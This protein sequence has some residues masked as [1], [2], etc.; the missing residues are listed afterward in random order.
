[1]PS[2]YRIKHDAYVSE[3]VNGTSDKAPSQN[4]GSTTQQFEHH[5]QKFEGG[6][7]RYCDYDVKRTGKRVYSQ[8][9]LICP[10][11][12]AVRLHIHA[13]ENGVLT[14]SVWKRFAQKIL[15]QLGLSIYYAR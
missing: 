14:P 5:L 4:D 15:E 10:E 3:D 1:M 2:K 7:L 11:Q 6:A 13:L 9:G 12:L 8:R